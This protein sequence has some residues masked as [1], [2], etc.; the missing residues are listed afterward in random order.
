MQDQELAGKVAIVTGAG[1]M[2]SIGRPIARLL[3]KAGA[4]VVITG[5]GRSPD[6]YP[7]DEKAAGWRD[8]ES[9]RAEIEA[10][11]GTCLALVSDISSESAVQALVRATVEK[12]GRLDIVVNN[13][14]AARGADRVP[15]V[16]LTHEVWKKVIET[17]L[18]GTFLLSRE[19]ARHMLKQ[20][21]GGSIINI[22]SIASKRAGKNTAAYAASKAGINALSRAMSQELGKDGIRVNALCPGII[23]TY[24][25]DDVGR[26]DA[27][28]QLIKNM[29]PLG[30]PGDG[31][32]V[33]ELCLFLV[34]ERG[35]WITG[36]AI[37]IDGGTAWQ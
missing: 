23:D 30:Y 28:R 37:N 22:S 33:A 14:G 11:G 21:A 8:I 9:V 13:A 4:K 2:R 17:N 12:L 18:D 27:W 29:I 6:R 31:N 25:M 5:T 26:D 10:A 34:S 24:R 15:V 7:D 1:R 32:E 19:A 3:A 20:G 35:K 16:E 36:Q